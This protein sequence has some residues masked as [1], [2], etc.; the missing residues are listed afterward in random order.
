MKMMGEWGGGE[1]MEAA[2]PERAAI[3]MAL[4]NICIALLS[5]SRS[6][7]HLIAS[8]RVYGCVYMLNAPFL[9]FDFA[10]YF[11]PCFHMIVCVCMCVCV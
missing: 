11:C 3:F 4:C 6:L 7:C 2:M 9:L 8:Q 5:L 1:V 10:F